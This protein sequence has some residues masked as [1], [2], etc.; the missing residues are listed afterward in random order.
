MIAAVR[1]QDTVSSA[2]VALK[3]VEATR[4][5]IARM[6]AKIKAKLAEVWGETGD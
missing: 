5:L 1:R 3:M 4:E 6:E 2:E